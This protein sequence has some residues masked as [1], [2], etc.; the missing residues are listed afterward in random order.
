VKVKIGAN[1]IFEVVKVKVGV[2]VIVEVVKVKVGVTVI[3]EL[4]KVKV[5]VTVIWKIPNSLTLRNSLVDFEKDVTLY[6]LQKVVF[7]T[8]SVAAKIRCSD[9]SITLK[10]S[11]TL[12][13]KTYQSN[14]I[15][16][17]YKIQIKI[18]FI[19]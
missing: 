4:M 19:F 8:L 16:T 12:F 14:P 15:F 5:G 2:T 6:P 11:I 7:R 9:S 13:L 10:Q 1:V 3:V 18:V 17:T